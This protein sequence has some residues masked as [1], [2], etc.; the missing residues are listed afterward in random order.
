MNFDQS[1]EI[2]LHVL[3]EHETNLYTTATAF[4]FLIEM[5][6]TKHR[7]SGH[8]GRMVH[9]LKPLTIL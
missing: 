4:L 9:F 8:T 7:S 6:G 1:S 3:C 5:A 2:W